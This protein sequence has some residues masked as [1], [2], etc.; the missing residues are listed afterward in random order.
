MPSADDYAHPDASPAGENLVF[1][2][3]RLGAAEGANDLY[4]IREDGSSLVKV[5]DYT[6]SI[7]VE[8][9]TVTLRSVGWPAFS[10]DGM[11]IAAAFEGPCSQNCQAD[12]YHGILTVEPDGSGLEVVDFERGA[13][14]RHQVHWTP[15]GRIFWLEYN[16]VTQDPEL[17]VFNPDD[18]VRLAITPPGGGLPDLDWL[19]YSAVGDSLVFQL[20]G[21]NDYR[22]GVLTYTSSAI[23]MS[24]PV[25][26]S[27]PDPNVPDSSIPLPQFDWFGWQR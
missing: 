8:G 2:A 16:T 1:E 21:T 3:H 14:S 10:P 15:E 5:L 26:L 25:A 9:G 6:T 23:S 12:E 27:V 24:T 17:F 19:A 18:S 11:R 4:V 13:G 20:T 22:Y 7:E